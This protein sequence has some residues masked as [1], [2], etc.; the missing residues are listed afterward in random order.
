MLQIANRRRRQSAAA[1]ASS[2]AKYF[3]GP[4]APGAPVRKDP[5]KKRRPPGTY[6][7]DSEHFPATAHACVDCALPLAVAVA[8]DSARE[9]LATARAAPAESAEVAAEDVAAEDAEREP[10]PAFP[11]LVAA[12]YC[13]AA[14]A[15]SLEHTAAGSGWAAARVRQPSS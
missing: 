3:R 12:A 10:L 7:G 15:M 4:R 2:T 8:A 11:V 9:P 1:R 13:V 6:A 14:P 5:K